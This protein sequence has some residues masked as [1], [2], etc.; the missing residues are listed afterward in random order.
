M[1]W[2]F[3]LYDWIELVSTAPFSLISYIFPPN[4]RINFF[5]LSCINK[6]FS[7]C[8]SFSTQNVGKNSRYICTFGFFSML[9][10]PT[11]TNQLFSFSL[12]PFRPWWF[13]YD[14]V[15]V[16][17]KYGLFV[18]VVVSTNVWRSLFSLMFCKFG[19]R[20]IFVVRFYFVKVLLPHSEGVLNRND[21]D[22]SSLNQKNA[23]L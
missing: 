14:C 13:R 4:M 9:L 1:F 10:K 6:S 17:D 15:Q 16:E 20:L 19:Y 18:A 3:I 5:F 12:S 11:W 8:F 7:D 22:P 21:I 2:I 23:L